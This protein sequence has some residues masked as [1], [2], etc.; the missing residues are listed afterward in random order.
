[1]NILDAKHRS[2]IVKSI[3]RKGDRVGNFVKEKLAKSHNIDLKEVES[4]DNIAAD[5]KIA[6]KER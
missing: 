6:V 3:K 4:L 2:T 1:M 5:D